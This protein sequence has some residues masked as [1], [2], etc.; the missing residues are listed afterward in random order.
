M[1][2]LFFLDKRDKNNSFI[3][4]KVPELNMRLTNKIFEQVSKNQL[5]KILIESLPKEYID[6]YFKKKIFYD[7]KDISS[8]IIINEWNFYNKKNNFLK[9]I[10]IDNSPFINIINKE[11]IGSVF[12]IKSS[13]IN[14]KYF[15]F[16]L[17]EKY[18]IYIKFLK[19]KKF[20]TIY[21]KK[22]HFD[23]FD[24][25]I[26]VNFVEGC[27]PNFRNDLFFLKKNKIKYSSIVYYCENKKLITK[28]LDGTKNLEDLEK[29]GI[30]FV[31]LW[32]WNNIKNISF[33][34]NIKKNIENFNNKDKFNLWLLKE[35]KKLI[36]QIN[37]WYCF[38]SDYNIKIHFNSE[39]HGISNVIKQIAIKKL[40]SCSIGKCRS[41][42]QKIENY[43]FGFYPNDIFFVWGTDSGN[44]IM[45]STNFFKH[46]IISGYPYQQSKNQFKEIFL[47][48]NELANQGVKF[49]LLL[50]DGSYSNNKSSTHQLFP[51]DQMSKY[52]NYFLR[53]LIEE[54]E[55]GLI[56]KSKKPGYLSSLNG[57]KE[58][59]QK[60]KETKRVYI[61]DNLGLE[62]KSFSKIVDFAIGTSVDFPSSIIQLAIYG[63]KCAIYDY[64]NFR[65][66]EKL[67][68]SWGE[69][70]VIFSD[71]DRILKEFLNHFKH[72]DIKS[73]FGDWSK[74]ISSY[75]MFCDD[76]GGERIEEYVKDLKNSLDNGKSVN[77]SLKIANDYYANKWGK[78]TFLR[79]D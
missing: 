44:S 78:E 57:I 13:R 16:F 58:L 63:S 27:N 59:L 46:V 14:L 37:F 51:N 33:L 56:I 29:K 5:Y 20:F 7:I 47:V 17:K 36:L 52:L 53:I 61:F 21:K 8:K 68:Y 79:F 9:E 65:P 66:S 62:P 24:T 26:G 35:I 28:Y 50:T 31:K 72:R 69:N 30:K 60:A 38:F 48:K 34:E 64:S 41:A 1:S 18:A 76:R 42:P 74:N 67:L 4:F 71:L 73:R 54:K 40:E 75:D 77:E 11:L 49:T 23:K 39:E 12:K 25:K 43:W 6:L 15:N 22:N 3:R 32:E 45:R 55:M 2:D 19:F 70:K 10:K